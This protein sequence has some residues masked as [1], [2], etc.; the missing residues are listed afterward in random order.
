MG[1]LP[2]RVIR[3][4]EYAVSTGLL[5]IPA[6]RAGKLPKTPASSTYP[7]YWSG[8]VKPSRPSLH[9]HLREYLKR[10]MGLRSCRTRRRHAAGT[11][12]P[13]SPRSAFLRSLP[14]WVV[15]VP[16][17]RAV[18]EDLQRFST[19]SV[20]LGNSRPVPSTFRLST[21]VRVSSLGDGAAA[22]ATKGLYRFRAATRNL[23]RLAGV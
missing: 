21:S 8:P 17:I 20:C 12:K 9:G 23:S 11:G 19:R 15:N 22:R 14:H 18:L 7:G 10:A 16:V 6:L 2:G 13:S 3:S 5:S 4:A 1:R